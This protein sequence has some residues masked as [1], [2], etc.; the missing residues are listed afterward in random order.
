[1]QTRPTL[2]Q[3]NFVKKLQNNFTKIFDGLHRIER[4]KIVHQQEFRLQFNKKEV[5]TMDK[6][7]FTDPLVENYITLSEDTTHVGTARERTKND[8]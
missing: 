7:G 1:M 2:G 4:V 8:T 6:P 3:N 5:Q